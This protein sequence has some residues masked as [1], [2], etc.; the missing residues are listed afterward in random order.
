MCSIQS[1]NVFGPQV[2]ADCRGGFDF[3][4]LFEEV[5]LTIVP[6]VLVFVMI[7]FRLVYLFKQAQNVKIDSLYHLKLVGIESHT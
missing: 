7:P 2:S 1:D 4:L 5:I 3:T 6:L